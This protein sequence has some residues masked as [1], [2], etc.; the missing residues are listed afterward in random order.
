M[1]SFQWDR[2]NRSGIMVFYLNFHT[3]PIWQPS[4]HIVCFMV[5]IKKGSVWEEYSSAKSVILK[6]YQNPMSLTKSPFAPF[7]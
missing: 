3:S 1:Q 5:R 6:S 2:N 4:G 7:K